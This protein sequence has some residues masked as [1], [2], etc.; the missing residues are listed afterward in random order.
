MRAN[1]EALRNVYDDHAEFC[2]QSLMVEGEDRAIV[3]MMLSPG[4]IRLHNAIAEQR[5]QGKPVRI[6][7]LKSRRI[8]ATTG[9]AAEFF[10]DTAFQAGIHTVV[11]AHDATSVENI[12][13]T[14]KRF[15][16]KY[17][18]FGIT[19][20]SGKRHQVELGPS[21]PLSDRIYYEFAGDPESSF[22]QIHTAGTATFGRSF[23]I[24]NVHFSEF[25]YYENPAAIL[26][27]VMSAVPKLPET[28]AII[29]GT[30]RTIGDYFHKMWQ[31][32]I[33]PTSGSEW[34]PIFMGWWEHPANRMPIA[35]PL[36]RFQDMLSREERELM[37]Q[38]SLS[39]EQMAWRRWTISNDFNGDITHFRREHPTTSDEAF[40]ASSRNRFSIPHIVKLHHKSDP[41]VGELETEDVGAGEKRMVLLPAER[42]ALRV[43]RRP[44]KGRLYVI[45]ADCAQGLD[46]NEGGLGASDPDYSVGQVLDRD[47]GEQVAVLRAR[48]MPGETG[49][50][51]ARLGRYYNMAQLCGERNPGGG[52]VSMLESV[53]NTD[54]PSSLLYHRSTSPDRDP[55][56]RGDRVGWDTTGVSRERL[57]NLLDENIRQLAIVLHDP[58]TVSELMTFVIKASGK[59]GANSGCHDDT[60][61][62]LAL[63]LIAITQMP[64]PRP[65]NAEQPRPA[66]TRYGRPAED[67]ARGDRVRFR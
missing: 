12:F 57:L 59:S 49:R 24:T 43:W 47:T 65:A 60:C 34:L 18:P 30:T 17:I 67:D 14:Y 10:H 53:M 4:Q 61:I 1:P 56:I 16:D 48:M 6:I 8:M 36:D 13:A 39:L 54:Y 26:A 33:D 41:L 7:Y 19:L 45:G 23:R 46:V 35:I 52:G 21:R 51:M 27:S 62:A 44:E 38:Y 2:R 32:A 22:I 58:V 64:R 15:H 63:A 50:Y 28:T 25:P 42:G 40:A 9:T 37:A 20:R 55:Q 66:I 29:E 5:K 3:P 11:M 31:T